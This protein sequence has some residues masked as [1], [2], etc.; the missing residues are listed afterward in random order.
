MFEKYTKM[1]LGV[2]GPRESIPLLL[3]RSSW[4]YSITPEFPNTIIFSAPYS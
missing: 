4:Q 3:E 2:T 1:V